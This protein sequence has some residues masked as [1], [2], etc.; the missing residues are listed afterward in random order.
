MCFL[1]QIILLDCTLICYLLKISCGVSMYIWYN[2]SGNSEK[3]SSDSSHL[4]IVFSQLSGTLM[5]WKV[6]LLPLLM[7]FSS[8]TGKEI[9][10][11]KWHMQLMMWVF[12]GGIQQHILLLDGRRRNKR[13]MRA[14][15]LKKPNNKARCYWDLIT[16][17]CNSRWFV[18]F[19]FWLFVVVIAWSF[20][21]ISHP[22]TGGWMLATVKLLLISCCQ[23]LWATCTCCSYF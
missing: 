2:N 20:C 4:N 21:H 15:S 11:K 14:M 16:H 13:D 18:L 3:Y 7:L 19:S 10:Q 6:P 17:G 23:S 8:F 9:F 12:D 5:V 1:K 22:L